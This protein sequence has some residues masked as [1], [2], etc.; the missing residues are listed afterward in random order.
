MNFPSIEIQG[1]ILSTD[2]LAKI[3]SEQATFQQGKDFNPDL[4]NAKLKDEISLAW[5]EAKGQWT[6]YKSKL[7]RLKEGETGTTETRNFWISP[8]LT[9]LGYNLTFNRQSE[10]LNGE[11]FPIGYRDSNLDGFPVY[12]GGY[13]ESLDKRPEN[14][15]LR[16]SPHAMVQEYLNYSEH[17]YG[18]VTNG[19]QLRL[20]RD[21]SR[22]TRLS[23]VEFN[24]EKMMEEDLYSDF[25]ILYRVL[26]ASRMPKKIDGGAESIIERYHQEGLEAGS[27]IRSKLGDAVKEAIKTLANGFI[28]HPNNTEL[29]EAV[30]S[31]KFS[32]DEYYRHQLRIIYRLLFLFVIEER[33]LVYA[34]NKTPEAKRFNQIYF[35]YYSL[36]RLRK[37]AKKLLPP[38]ASRHYDVW[39]GLISTFS[40]F[41]KKEIGEKL[42]IMALQGDLFGYHAISGNGYDLHQC[43]LNNAVLLN[44]IKSLSYFENNNGVLIAVNYGG[45]DVEEFGSV[46]EGLLELKLEVKKIEGSDQYSCSFDTSNER[47]KSG[48]HYTPEELVQPLIKHSL[49]YLIEDRI[50]AYQQKKATKEATI[51]SLLSLKIADVACGSGHILLSAARRLSLEIARVQTGE[52]QPN[53]VA[54]RKAMKDVVRNCIYGVDKNPLAVEL[55]K[56]ALWLEAY[57]PGEPL[58]FLDHHIKCGDAI[59]GLAH[60]SEL[61]NGIAD[62]AFKTLPG[63]D[64]GIAKTWR[65]KN[66][67]ERK[68]RAAKALQLKAEF[69]KSTENSVQEAM[70]EYKTFSQLPE[71]TPEEIERKAKAYQKFIDGKGFTF[72][73]AM[74][75]TQVAQ[76]F[77]PK[78]EANKDYLMTDADYR[79]ILSGYKGWQDRKVAKATAI[80]HE[81]RF[82]H[83]F[84]EFP[85]VF[86]QG[87]F[88]C[89]LGNPP[90]LGAKKIRGAYGDSFLN[91]LHIYYNAG[92][93]TDL[94]CYFVNRNYSIIKESKFVSLIT[95]NTITEGDTKANSIDRIVAQNGEIIFAVKSIPWIGTANLSVSLISFFKGNW[96]KKKFIANKEVVN[97]N[98]FFEDSIEYQSP[99][100]LLVNQN[101]LFKGNDFAGEGFIIT[102]EEY[103]SLLVINPKNK[104]VLFPLINGRN[105]NDDYQ[106]TNDRY[107]INYFDWN[108]E[109]A[110]QYSEVFSIIEERVKPERE[111][112]K[113]I[114]SWNKFVRENYWLF[115]AYRVALNEA[116][117]GKRNCF[118]TS[119]VTKHLNFSLADTRFVFSNAVYVYTNSSFSEYAILQC[120][121][122]NEW[123]RKY[124]SSLE[125]RLRYT[126]TD[127]FETFPFPSSNKKENLKSLGE[128]YHEHRRQLMLSM[129]LGLTKTYNLFHSNAI[130]A[131]VVNEKDKQVAALQKHLEK[132]ANT[133][134][135]NEAIQG[136]RKLRELHVQMDEAVLTAYGWNNDESSITN[137]DENTNPVIRNSKL[138]IDLR[139]DFYEVDYLPENDRV[140]FTI[141]PD[142][143]KEVL[144]RLLELNHKIHEEEVKAGLWE[145]KKT[146]SKKSTI[147]NEPNAAYGG[148]LFNQ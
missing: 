137:Y 39:Q 7:A 112:F 73:K 117:V 130:T 78:T 72:L 30:A 106:L 111:K 46:Y 115:G 17:L 63:D 108:F 50:K 148:D 76:F 74:A 145:K 75:D 140:R 147:V 110:K 70:A 3:R 1:S 15:Q 36:L 103:D 6:I 45:L 85:E 92:A 81:Q 64:K 10:E 52:E 5:Q 56:I 143:R 49:E 41:E 138:K 132:A 28:N 126:T 105:I 47:G 88:D 134:S 84:I 139:H 97:I 35:N 61:E 91:Y 77:I 14:K 136:I 82:F 122:H 79:L 53:P 107:I 22:I 60:R 124:C 113:P 93:Q 102:K 48:S 62:E 32:A 114:N 2:L 121:L 42:G 96:N 66:V 90:Y 11:S 40:L 12:V 9:N 25:V 19:R 144:K 123:I 135:F 104:E 24:L 57:N 37:L 65:D 127:G 4:T 133:I 31:D 68:E 34:D 80:A 146:S 99:Y 86:S 58:N 43:Y 119:V 98:S 100:S 129:Q 83:W 21:A 87:G 67:K 8:L 125:S 44:I 118:V 116:L 101:K 26:H 13:H 51:Q 54:I 142:A 27:T 95:T 109:K 69:E 20:L 55:C 71:T 89:V 141:H 120:S 33:N 128:A 94:I 38:E 18:M 23:Y 131:Q 16:V 29:R 59:V